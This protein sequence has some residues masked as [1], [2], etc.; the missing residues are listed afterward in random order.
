MISNDYIACI[1]SHWCIHVGW[2]VILIP[3]KMEYTI[4]IIKT[5]TEGSA[6][7]MCYRHHIHNLAHPSHHLC[8]HYHATNFTFILT[9]TI[10]HSLPNWWYS[11]S[12]FAFWSNL[13]YIPGWP[14]THYVAQSELKLTILLLQPS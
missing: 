11:C 3:P 5:S 13:L 1:Y 12:F 4:H 8:L 6:R 10:T 7:T 9:S 2:L 14:W